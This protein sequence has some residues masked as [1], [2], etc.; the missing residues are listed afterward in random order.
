MVWIVLI[1]TF[2]GADVAYQEHKTIEKQS[3]PHREAWESYDQENLKKNDKAVCDTAI[4]V[5]PGG[6]LEQC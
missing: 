5:A 6:N 1:L 4:W 2:F 3:L